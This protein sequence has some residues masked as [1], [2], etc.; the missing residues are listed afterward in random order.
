MINIYSVPPLNELPDDLR[1]PLHELQA[2]VRYLI[3][4]ARQEGD[5]VASMVID[6]II[7]KLSQIETAAYRLANP[8]PS[9]EGSNG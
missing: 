2:D 5:E 3:A 9:Q 8:L 6:S 4:R 1:V 7:N